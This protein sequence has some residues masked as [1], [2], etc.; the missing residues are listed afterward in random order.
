MAQ[1]EIL[2]FELPVGRTYLAFMLIMVVLSHT[3]GEG[4][5][6]DHHTTGITPEDSLISIVEG[7][8]ILLFNFWLKG[9]VTVH[10]IK[11]KVL[12][13][14]SLNDSVLRVYSL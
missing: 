12:I 11:D 6:L 1:H 8:L 7:M 10:L 9:P 14:L 4:G 2:G 13:L 5:T 3:M